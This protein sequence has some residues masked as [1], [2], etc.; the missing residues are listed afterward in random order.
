MELRELT[1]PYEKRNVITYKRD[2]TTA[3]IKRIPLQHIAGPAYRDADRK[4]KCGQCYC[5]IYVYFD[6]LQIGVDIGG[7]VHP[8]L[9]TVDSILD[10]VKKQMLE[11]PEM[12]V[13]GMD[14]AVHEGRF[15]S[16]AWIEFARYAA[17]DRVE[18]YQKARLS[19]IAERERREAELQKTLAAKE[20]QQRNEKNEAA[21]R[22]VDQALAII[23]SDGRLANESIT[24]CRAT[25]SCSEYKLVNYIA[26]QLGVDI[27]LKVQGWI[28]SK[29][30][31]IDV[32]GGSVNSF[33]YYGK[34]SKTFRH[35]MNQIIDVVRDDPDRT[36]IVDQE[37]HK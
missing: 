1:G 21:Q 20:A 10:S 25:C 9:Q 22:I 5:H 6:A 15:I 7:V 11:T 34:L 37:S 4:D 13:A 27:P 23:R 24:I 28:N 12:I 30:I 19:Y 31:F 29:L 35:Y 33:S 26:R 14:R 18:V 17:P 16:N 36:V 8:G 2:N 32:K 3:T